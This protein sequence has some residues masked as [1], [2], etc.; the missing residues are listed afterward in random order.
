MEDLLIAINK[1]CYETLNFESVLYEWRASW[2]SGRQPVYVPRFLVDVKWTCDTDH[3]VSKWLMFNDGKTITD[4]ST[5]VMFYA[6]LDGNNQD[7]MATWFIENG[8]TGGGR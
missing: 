8:H 3:L 6:S 2:N 7:R 5:F 1:F 4:P